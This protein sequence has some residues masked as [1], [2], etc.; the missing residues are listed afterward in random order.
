MCPPKQRPTRPR[1][2][3]KT[4]KSILQLDNDLKRLKDDIIRKKLLLATQPLKGLQKAHQIKLRVRKS[5]S[6]L[7]STPKSAKISFF[8]VKGLVNQDMTKNISKVVKGY[9]KRKSK[10]VVRLRPSSKKKLQNS[11]KSHTPRISMSS[12][13]R[14]IRIPNLSRPMVNL[15]KFGNVS[16][17]CVSTH[18]G[19]SRN[20]NEDRVSIL[21][22]LPQR[23]KNLSTQSVK[24]CSMFAIYDG[25]GGDSCCNYLKENLHSIIFE[26]LDL[27][28][29]ET[30]LQNC[31]NLAEAEF[32]DKH[33]LDGKNSG[34]CA[35]GMIC[36]DKK[37]VFFNVGDSRAFLIKGGMREIVACSYDHK[38][39]FF[40]EMNRIFSNGGEL[41]R[42]V[43]NKCET[44]VYYARNSNEFF[45][46]DRMP[47]MRNFKATPIVGPWRVK[48]GGLSVTPT[49]N[50]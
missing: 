29:I 7:S 44:T 22:N 26:K 31:F 42:V 48:P 20:Y 33:V 21:L 40:G 49:S 50:I 6:L 12:L 18:S 37:L 35:I 23:Y 8:G 11:R 43:S 39:Q 9:K 30:S 28:H 13:L 14:P 36:I 24:N 19:I 2:S 10:S 38:P 4:I 16:S 45:A 25:H 27:Q 15:K 46:I 5:T 41:Y 17:F 1:S 34:S 3:S 47:I 32:F